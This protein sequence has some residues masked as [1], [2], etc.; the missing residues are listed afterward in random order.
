MLALTALVVALAP[1]APE[2]LT[3]ER[4]FSDPPLEGRGPT[5]LQLSPGG[6]YVS[7]LRGSDKDSDVLDLWGIRLD[8]G[9]DAKPELLVS[10]D[11]LLG[12]KEQK[13]TEQERM[14]LERK[15]ISKRGITSYLWC[16]DD[17]KSLVFPLSGDLYRVTLAD[18]K[19]ERLTNDEDKPEL[20]PVCS[21]SGK[22]VAFVKDNAVVVLDV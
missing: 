3:L 2:E 20:N 15:R 16:G 17:A 5:A 9:A 14:Q 4:I 19:V 21:K 13:L 18:G 7:F 12:G 11:E 8:R 10:S 22:R 1:A 6:K